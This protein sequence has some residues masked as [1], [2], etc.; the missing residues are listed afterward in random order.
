MRP[1]Q[2][3]ASPL[4]LGAAILVDLMSVITVGLVLTGVGLS[5]VAKAAALALLNTPLFVLDFSHY[6]A[7]TP[8]M[9]TTQ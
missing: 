1:I 8:G 3:A 5:F 4:I 6:V 2:I 7:K 9:C